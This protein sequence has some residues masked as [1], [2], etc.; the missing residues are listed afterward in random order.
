MTM[1]FGN[2]TIE[3]LIAAVE[4]LVAVVVAMSIREWARATAATRLGDPTPRLWRRVTF[5]PRSWFDPFG[6]GVLP[7]LIAI[8]W[9]VTSPTFPV[10]SFPVA[11]YA[12]P[13]PL[14]PSYFRNHRRDSILVSLAGPAA[15]LVVG[16]AAALVL[17]SLSGDTAV[18]QTTSELA[19]AVAVFAWVHCSLAVFHLIP[20]PG[21]DGARMLA[22]ALP[23]HAREVYR[24]GDK[25]LAL[26]VLL[27]IFVLG[28]LVSIQNALVGAVCDAAAGTDCLFEIAR[29]T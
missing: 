16:I 1:E 17:R 15:D 29:P 19:Q 3:G 14:D 26:W 10:V 8:L 11:A 20:I 23:P 9:S 2:F 5:S 13:A 24:N 7:G 22:L 12:K 21:L 18:L 28:F 27:A 4:M 6:S 25:Y